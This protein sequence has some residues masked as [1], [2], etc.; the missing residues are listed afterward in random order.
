MLI[1][2]KNQVADM[3]TD[4]NFKHQEFLDVVQQPFSFKK[5]EHHAEEGSRMKNKR[6]WWQNQS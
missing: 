2:T 3:L 4:G 5:T 6:R 1:D